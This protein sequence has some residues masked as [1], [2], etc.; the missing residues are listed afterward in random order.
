MS[1]IKTHDPMCPMQGLPDDTLAAV[2]FKSG[3]LLTCQCAL[4]IEV[5]GAQREVDA[6]IFESLKVW[7][8]DHSGS[9]VRELIN[10]AAD[11]IRGEVK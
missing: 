9:D 1:D 5:R 6:Q 7:N 3:E 8:C 10:M 2:L 4:I 11:A